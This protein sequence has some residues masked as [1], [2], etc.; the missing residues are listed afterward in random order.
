MDF[1]LAAEITHFQETSFGR[2]ESGIRLN[3]YKDRMFR[4]VLRALARQ[5]PPPARI[6]DVGCSYGGFPIRAKRMGYEVFGADILLEA[7]EYVRRIGIPATVASSIGA[8]G[9][10]VGAPFDVISCLDCHVYW[11]DQPG[12]LRAAYKNLR[13]GGCLVLRVVDK[14]WLFSLGLRLRRVNPS[15]GDRILSASVNDHRFSMPVRSLLRLL[16]SVGFRVVYASPRGAVHS[17]ATRWIAKAAFAMG[18][19][20][21]ALGGPFLAPGALILARKA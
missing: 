15:I 13:P 9:A 17:D 21:R 5:A 18:T 6:L 10:E 8:L 11:P 1:D 3:D 2:Q 14:S 16:E 7:V 20:S 12:E 19:A 4:S